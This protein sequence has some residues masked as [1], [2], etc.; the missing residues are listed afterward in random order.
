MHQILKCAIFSMCVFG[1][2]AVFI[3]PSMAKGNDYQGWEI[4]S[5]YNKLYNPKERDSIKGTIVKFV[6]VTPMA[7]MAP[8]TG[9]ILDEGGGDTVLIHVCPESFASARETGLKR[10]DWLKVKGVWIDIEDETV[11]IAAKIKK[12]NDYSFK[13]RLTGDGTPF[14]TMSEEQLAKERAAE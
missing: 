2:Q 12:D 1:L 6:K 3:L 9:F 10:G 13:V 5:E 7:G 11:F 14:W 8:G 4:G